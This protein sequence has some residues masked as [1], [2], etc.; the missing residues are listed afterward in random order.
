MGMTVK[1]YED[2]LKRDEHLKSMEENGEEMRALAYKA[3]QIHNEACNL[4]VVPEKPPNFPPKPPTFAPSKERMYY[5]SNQYKSHPIVFRYKWEGGWAAARLRGLATRTDIEKEPNLRYAVT[6]S[7]PVLPSDAVT[8]IFPH[9]NNRPMI[10]NVCFD[11]SLYSTAEDAPQG[12][13]HCV[14]K[15][16]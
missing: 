11:E 15:K 12:S 1:E 2:F 10:R 8:R 5:K 6:P 9:L 3:S 7:I 16:V 13:W 14:E 4:K